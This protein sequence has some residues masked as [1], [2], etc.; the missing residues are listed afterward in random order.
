MEHSVLTL[1]KLKHRFSKACE[2]YPPPQAEWLLDLP[3]HQLLRI[4]LHHCLGCILTGY[5]SSV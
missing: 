2:R 1:E 4:F 5:R 3:R